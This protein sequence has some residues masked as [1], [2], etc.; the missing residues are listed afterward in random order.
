MNVALDI[1]IVV[2][3]VAAAYFGL[4]LGI[5]RAGTAVSGIVGGVMLAKYSS[6]HVTPYVGRVFNDPEMAQAISVMAV[7]LG[8][9]IA[10][11]VAGVMLRRAFQFLFL[12]WLD[13][14]AGAIAGFALLLG[15]WSVGL[16]VVVPNLSDELAE[17]VERAPVAGT[18]MRKGPA[19]LEA[20][21]GFVRDYAVARVPGLA[22]N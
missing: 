8:V 1:A 17:V 11:I 5:I 7:V 9:L 18:L 15:V 16:N 2:T 14:S 13:A 12:G 4:R 3:T 19:L 20:A 22:I 21:P 6:P 10:S